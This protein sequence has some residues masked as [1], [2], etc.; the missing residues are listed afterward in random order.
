MNFSN[1]R[2]LR[3]RRAM[4]YPCISSSIAPVP[5]SNA[6]P[7]PSPP[8]NVSNFLLV[9]QLLAVI[10]C[11]KTG[12]N[13]LLC[14]FS[15]SFQIGTYLSE[16]SATASENSD[17]DAEYAATTSAEPHFLSIKEVDDLIRDLDFIKSGAEL[18]TSRLNEWNLLG[19]DCK[20]TANRKALGVFCL[21]WCYWRPLLLYR[22]RR[23][24]SCC[25]N[26]LWSYSMA[27][28]HW[29]FNLGPARGGFREYI[30]PG[31]GLKGLGRVQ[32]SVL[33]FGIAP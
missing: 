17:T 20:S 11:S 26:R 14:T 28:F 3:E 16:D 13:F 8:S 18:L 33:S 19:N 4:T 5:H 25:W 1:H 6:L 31:P 9:M 7:V 29:H 22:R 2:K 27:A 23:P 21:L 15:L 24:V 10:I 12:S 30:V 32:V